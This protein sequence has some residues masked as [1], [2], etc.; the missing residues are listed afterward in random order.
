MN[1]TKLFTSRNKDEI[2]ER[3]D[4]QAYLEIDHKQRKAY[5]WL[6]NKIIATIAFFGV[7]ETNE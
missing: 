4:N 5:V 1:Q 2:I 3:E 7:Y 6:N